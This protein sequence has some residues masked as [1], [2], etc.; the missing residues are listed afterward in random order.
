MFIYLNGR[1]I[2]QS[3][4]TISI[5]DHGYLYGLGLFETF[6]IYNGHPFLLDDHFQ[7]M[8]HGLD[9][10]GID[11]S[12]SRGEATEI[13]NQ[14]LRLNEYEDAY[15]RWNVSAGSKELGLYTGIYEQP[16]VSV[17][18]KPLPSIV[19]DK[20]IVVLNRARNTPEG[21]R[22]LK[23][24]HYL[25]N[26]LAKREL[27]NSPNME[28]IFL[29]KEGWVAEGIVSNVF[30]IKDG[31]VY[32][33]SIETGILDGVTRKYVRSILQQKHIPLVEGL[34]AVT[35]L[36]EADEV[37]LTN[38]IQEVVRVESCAGTAY[39]KES[40]IINMLKESFEMETTKRWSIEI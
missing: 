38:S 25:N 29:T 23:S 34:F 6:R 4:A 2:D 31:V 10:L 5:M 27:G 21:D 39:A 33:P 8:Q 17:L 22:R 13:L 1:F 20:E 40:T 37:F 30:W 24:H 11:Y 12:I 26:V 15:V 14:L 28:G 9:E 19:T 36:L 16:T 18:M 7:R 3:E 32:T 35:S